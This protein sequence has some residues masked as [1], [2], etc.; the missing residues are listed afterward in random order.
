MNSLLIAPL[1][2]LLSAVLLLL[3]FFHGA[4]FA[5][6]ESDTPIID[7]AIDAVYEGD[8]AAAH[9]AADKALATHTEAYYVALAK[10]AK[11]LALTHESG[12]WG[13][14]AEA[15]KLY[16]EILA[17]PVLTEAH[18]EDR[19]YLMHL[20]HVDALSNLYA[21]KPSADTAQKIKMLYQEMRVAGVDWLTSEYGIYEPAGTLIAARYA[22]SPSI[23]A[24]AEASRVEVLRM[25]KSDAK[26][27]GM[28]R[29]KFAA[30][31][32][33]SSLAKDPT[34]LK[35]LSCFESS[36]GDEKD[37]P[38]VLIKLGVQA[39]DPAL[40]FLGHAGAGPDA[41]RDSLEGSLREAGEKSLPVS[42]RKEIRSCLAQ[43]AKMLEAEKLY[44][45]HRKTRMETQSAGSKQMNH[46]SEKRYAGLMREAV[47]AYYQEQKC[48]QYPLASLP[49]DQLNYVC[50]ST[51]FI[52]EGLMPG[53]GPAILRPAEY[54]QLDYRP[55]RRNKVL[56]E[57][58]SEAIGKEAYDAKSPFTSGAVK[59]FLSELS[60]LTSCDLP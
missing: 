10:D 4:V 45:E 30:A 53:T 21:H 5:D 51:S 3:C 39:D 35:K 13:G 16:Q 40:G 8:L 26:L 2:A 36:L 59:L 49:L 60:K 43:K 29:P 28:L 37:D 25:M 54:E 50:P 22:L 41:L 11:A 12:S 20:V 56:G 33:S 47:N 27:A 9:A 6:G 14:S 44:K 57:F 34:L 52:G 24:A 17:M 32:K 1:R 48:D 31:V 58:C 55:F 15:V 23:Q 18:D 46:N 19:Q 42:V 38:L 7:A